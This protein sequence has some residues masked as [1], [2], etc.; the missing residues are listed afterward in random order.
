LVPHSHTGLIWG[1]RSRF[2]KRM[3]KAGSQVY[4]VGPVPKNSQSSL[5]G[6]N[7]PALLKGLPEGVGVWTDAVE[8]IAP[9]LAGK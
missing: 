3:A 6:L 9:A 5:A 2:A 7:D 4:L 1:W 8:I